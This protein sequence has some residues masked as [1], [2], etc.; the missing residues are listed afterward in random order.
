MYSYFL[1]VILNIHERANAG[2]KDSADGDLLEIL[3]NIE[4]SLALKNPRFLSYLKY[5]INYMTED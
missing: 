4:Y 1:V 2:F 3:E 5:D